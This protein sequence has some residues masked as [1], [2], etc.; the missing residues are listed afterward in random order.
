MYVELLQFMPYVTY[1]NYVR[2]AGCVFAARFCLEGSYFCKGFRYLR[3][4]NILDQKKD[5]L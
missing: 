4:S 1:I 5:Q 3:M 2:L